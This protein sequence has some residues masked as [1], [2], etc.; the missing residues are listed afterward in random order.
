MLNSSIDLGTK[1][2]P[3]IL[4][5]NWWYANY[6]IYSSQN[7]IYLSCHLLHHLV[8][9]DWENSWASV[10][11]DWIILYKEDLSQSCNTQLCK[12]GNSMLACFFD[13]PSFIPTET[14][15]SSDLAL[16][17]RR[18]SS[19]SITSCITAHTIKPD[20]ITYLYF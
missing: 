13:T 11:I 20:G 8:T 6:F 10:N 19:I 9:K 18:S 5:A 14:K 17:V 7:F 3:N 16:F 4:D 12:F 2:N 15:V 1:S